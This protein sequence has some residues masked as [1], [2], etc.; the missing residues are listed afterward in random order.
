MAKPKATTP[1]PLGQAMSVVSTSFMLLLSTGIAP[2]PA[3]VLA[4]GAAY[5]LQR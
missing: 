4:V 1:A 2:I 3:F 5:L